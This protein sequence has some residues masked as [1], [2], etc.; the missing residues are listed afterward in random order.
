MA[1]R[2]G[3]PGPLIAVKRRAALRLGIVAPV[4]WLALIAGSDL[5]R[6]DIDA[7]TDYISELGERGSSSAPVFRSAGFLL[8]GFLYIVLA[9]ALPLI[10]PERWRATIV[11][12]FL[13]LDGIGR[14]GAGVYPCDPGCD[15]VSRTTA[16]TYLASA[17]VDAALPRRSS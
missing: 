6:P 13:A 7:V 15:G 14:M 11:G 3:L 10:L 1:R 9:A 16:S 17:V 12:L 5:Y 8:T 2:A 4:L